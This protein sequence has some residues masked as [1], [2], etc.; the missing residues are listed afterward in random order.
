MRWTWP[1]SFQKCRRQISVVCKL[2]GLWHFIMAA[3]MNYNKHPQLFVFCVQELGMNI[4]WIK[5][6][7]STFFSNHAKC[8]LSW[9]L[10]IQTQL[11]HL[12][13]KILWLTWAY[14]HKCSVTHKTLRNCLGYCNHIS[15]ML[16]S[17]DI[18]L[19][20]SSEITRNPRYLDN[21]MTN[22]SRQEGWLCHSNI[23]DN[24][25]IFLGNSLYYIR[26]W[27]HS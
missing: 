7:T 25:L 23:E 8:T 2:Q 22:E 3:H 14:V 15:L 16:L 20:K 6:H 11:P 24:V 26:K 21:S 19:E 9:A 1:S 13:M 27:G 5:I 10:T 12:N 17:S 18:W 4:Q